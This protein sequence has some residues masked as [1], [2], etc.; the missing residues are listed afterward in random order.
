MSQLAYAVK[1]F[2][3]VTIPAGTSVESAITEVNSIRP[4]G[5]FASQLVV[6]SGAGTVDVDLHLSIDGVN[7]VSYDKLFEDKT[8]I[9]APAPGI[10]E[11]HAFAVCLKF[12]VV[13]TET[14]G[15]STVVSHTIGVQ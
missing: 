14:A 10:I 2:E 6:E 12:K 1:T 13:I 9:N 3:S 15:T 7:F 8:L 11:N 5:N 4:L